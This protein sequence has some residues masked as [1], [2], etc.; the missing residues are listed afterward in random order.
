MKRNLFL[1][2][3]AG[4]LAVT[5]LAGC[6]GGEINQAESEEEL[7]KL[8]TSGYPIQTETRL[9]V[10]A[11]RGGGA[12]GPHSD[13]L[14][15]P[16]LTNYEE[17]LGVK[18]DWTFPTAGQEKQ[19][20]NLLL[21]AGDLPDLVGWYWTTDMPG[22]AERAISDGYIS[23]LN[24]Y[25]DDYAPNFKAYLEKNEQAARD[26]R[27]NNG[28]YYYVPSYAND[29]TAG[30]VS[31]GY[32]FRQ[33]WLKELGLEK[34]ETIAEWEEVLRAFRD[35]KG[36]E[37]PL[38]LNTAYLSRGLTSAFDMKLGWY[39]DGEG[40]AKYGYAEPEYKAFLETM[41]RWY[42]EGL[43]D[44]NLATIDAKGIDAKMLNGKSGASFG[45]NGANLGKW[46]QAGQE[47]DP[48]Y[49]LTAVRFPVANKGDIPKFGTKD[50]M[51]YMAGYAIS[52][53]SAHKAL[54]MKVLD[55]GFSEE[56]STFLQFGE[57]GKTYTVEDGKMK[58]T[59][60]IAKNPD[61]LSQTEAIS[62]YIRNTENYPLYK[63]HTYKAPSGVEFIQETKYNYTQ[64]EEA[65]EIWGMNQAPKFDMP[66]LAPS[67]TSYGRLSTDIASYA[68]EMMLKFITGEEPLS[69]WDT[70]LQT[71]SSRGYDQLK[72]I[73]QKEYDLYLKR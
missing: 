9:K 41:H 36:A 38:T 59:D 16:S 8:K 52:G 13:P 40:H 43:I 44:R 71:L 58:Y 70:Y 67:D 20:F 33:D 49:D 73:M 56:G 47:L 66:T 34:P 65:L 48:A 55:F 17:K 60:L 72:E 32:I 19:Q 10:W 35:K 64:Q 6:G 51:V 63:Q 5:L 26:L 22:G 3:L 69:N 46:L 1:S 53:K 12:I 57:E 18:F 27:T 28:N 14:T 21:A 23:S 31:A 2:A 4:M 42:E 62:Y 29:Q 39:T 50:A 15:Y 37:A 45:W 7:E 25:M 11:Y 24:D 30:T 68:E 54:A 61:G